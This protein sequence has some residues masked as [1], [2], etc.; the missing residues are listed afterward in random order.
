VSAAQRIKRVRKKETTEIQL[1]LGARGGREERGLEGIASCGGFERV[2]S[3]GCD[4]TVFLD[5]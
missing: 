3:H 2:M 4:A 1:I 5:E